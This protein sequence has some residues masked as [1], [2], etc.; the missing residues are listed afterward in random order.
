[1]VASCEM[2]VH[3]HSQVLGLFSGSGWRT[4]TLA[5]LRGRSLGLT[6]EGIFHFLNYFGNICRLFSTYFAAAIE[7]G[8]EPVSS[9]NAHFD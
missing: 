9:E 8:P 2:T 4:R 1:M 3:M 7:S 5:L 6:F